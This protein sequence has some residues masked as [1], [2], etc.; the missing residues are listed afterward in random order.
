MVLIWVFLFLLST[1]CVSS[2]IQKTEWE[3]SLV[4]T[5]MCRDESVNLRSNLPS[6]ATFTDYFVFLIDVRTIDQSRETIAEILDPKGIPY[7]IENYT[8]IG[9][10]DSRTLSLSIAQDRFPQASHVMIADPDWRPDLNTIDKRQLDL[11]A[12]VFRFVV[13]DRNGVTRRRMDWYVI[14]LTIF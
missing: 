12:Q 2:D 7:V 4:V 14:L 8:F 11:S 6:W 9:F 5:M 1:F 3:P 13:F 10:G